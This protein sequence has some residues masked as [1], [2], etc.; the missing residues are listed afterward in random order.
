MAPAEVYVAI[1]DLLDVDRRPWSASRLAAAKVAIGVVVEPV[2]GG[3]ATDVAK[4]IHDA[5]DVWITL[6]P[7]ARFGCAFQRKGCLLFV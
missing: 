2:G 4:A 7:D 1:V 6:A 3:Q 5:F